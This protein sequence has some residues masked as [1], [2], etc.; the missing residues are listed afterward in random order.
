MRRDPSRMHRSLT[1]LAPHALVQV[2][3]GAASGM[4]RWWEAGGAERLRGDARREWQALRVSAALRWWGWVGRVPGCGV[5]STT[6]LHP[7]L[8]IN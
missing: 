2:A 1:H 7:R 4:A 8:P 3:Q 6:W 5:L